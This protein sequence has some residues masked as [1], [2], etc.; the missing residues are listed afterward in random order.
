MFPWGHAAVAYLLLAGARRRW[1]TT[2]TGTAVVAVL[3]ASQL[4]D[5]ID[6]PLSWKLSLLPTGR[7]LAHSLVTGSVLLL[8]LLGALAIAGLGREVLLPVAIGWLSHSLSDAASPILEA[9]FQELGYLGWPILPVIEYDG[10]ENLVGIFA[11]ADPLAPF[12]LLQVG[13]VVLAVT[14][15]WTDGRPGLQPTREWVARR[16]GRT[17]ETD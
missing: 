3:V 9:E 8:I 6:K 1:G 16:L 10:P 7:T 17:G 11:R 5:L 15:W 13:L 4:P 2:M 12:F 14:L